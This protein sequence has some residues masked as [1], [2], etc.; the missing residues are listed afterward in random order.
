MTVL[1]AA[2]SSSPAAA[3]NVMLAHRDTAIRFVRLEKLNFRELLPPPPAADSVAA[4]ADLETVLQVQ[5]ARTPEQ[6]EWAKTVDKDDVFLNREVLGE[7]FSPDRLPATAAFFKSLGTDLKAVDAAAK[8]P[9][10]RKRP[11]QVDTR[12]KPCVPLPASSS[13]PSG[14]GLQAFVW[15]HLL[16]EM[17]PWK[18][19]ALID[20]AQRAAWGRVL[21]GVHFPSDVVAGRRLAQAFLAACRE[22]AEF[23]NE[24]EAARQEVAAALRRAESRR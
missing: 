9:F 3:D 15:A 12:V 7:W 24:L 18:H 22:S 19:D 20:R 2:Q 4:A 11:Y 23:R 16:A 17:V 8:A 21:G 13:Y 10:H 5:A 1:G 14:S 6:T